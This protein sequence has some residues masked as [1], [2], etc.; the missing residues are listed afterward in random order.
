MTFPHPCP[1]TRLSLSLT[2]LLANTANIATR[3][4]KVLK[5]CVGFFVNE[6]AIEE[7]R[8]AR[9]RSILGRRDA[10]LLDFEG[11]AFEVVDFLTAGVEGLRGW[12]GTEEVVE[13]GGADM[14]GVGVGMRLWFDVGVGER[15]RVDVALVVAVDRGCEGGAGGYG[16]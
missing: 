13:G 11:V 1:R 12:G 2:S 4:I 16:G 8:F 5:T 10:G 15:V 3:N 7:V 14:D 6:C 9:R